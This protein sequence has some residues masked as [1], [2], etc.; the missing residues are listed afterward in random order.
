MLEVCFMRAGNESE[1]FKIMLMVKAKAFRGFQLRF[2]QCVLSQKCLRAAPLTLC[3]TA[4]KHTSLTG[5][6]KPYVRGIRLPL[7]WDTSILV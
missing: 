3:C 6:L 7:S 2:L 4:V 1:G 5:H